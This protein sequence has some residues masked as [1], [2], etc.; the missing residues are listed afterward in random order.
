MEE[1]VSF[2]KFLFIK[3]K[4]SKSYKYKKKYYF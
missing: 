4:Y 2:F 3:N 1:M